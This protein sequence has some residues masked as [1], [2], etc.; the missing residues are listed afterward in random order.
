MKTMVT[1]AGF[2]LVLMPGGLTGWETFEPHAARWSQERKVIRAQLLNV[3]FG[4]R[5]EVV[6]S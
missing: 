3:D 6:N 2:P 4:L 5:G 1:G